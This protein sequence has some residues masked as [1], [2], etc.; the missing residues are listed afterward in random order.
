MVMRESNCTRRS[1]SRKSMGKRVSRKVSKDMVEGRVATFDSQLG[2]GRKDE[3]FS[4]ECL[5][6]SQLAIVLKNG[7]EFP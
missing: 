1:N 6:L 2:N 4:S 7:E 5:A 3:G